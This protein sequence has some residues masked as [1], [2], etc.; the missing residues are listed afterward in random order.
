MLEI[1]SSS[2]SMSRNAAL[3]VTKMMILA[4]CVQVSALSP[5]APSVGRNI[6]T[7]QTLNLNLHHQS[8]GFSRTF[9]KSNSKSKSKLWSQ[10]VSEVD[11]EDP[12]I[13]NGEQNVTD[14]NDD[15]IITELQISES[16]PETGSKMSRFKA[17]LPGIIRKK[18]N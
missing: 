1:S 14:G 7:H 10:S 12:I 15:E 9:T 2:S 4:T 16:T 6:H 18:K 17:A 13:V 3:G 8:H 11:S 5:I